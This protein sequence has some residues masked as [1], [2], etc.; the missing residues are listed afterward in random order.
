MG[1]MFGQPVQIETRLRLKHS[2]AQTIGG[3]AIESYAA[4]RYWRCR[5]R[6]SLDRGRGRGCFDDP[7]LRSARRF[8]Q[9]ARIRK[10]GLEQFA[11]FIGQRAP[12]RHHEVSSNFAGMRFASDFG[13]K[14]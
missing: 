14:T 6:L 9:R 11:L 13:S 4:P 8:F 12:A 1:V 3:V 2:T 10:S 7:L 5:P